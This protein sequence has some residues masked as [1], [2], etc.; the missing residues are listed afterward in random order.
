MAAKI[1]KG[2]RIIVTTGDFK[3]TVGTVL[4][5]DP[6][7]S[8]ATVEGVNARLVRPNRLQR[9]KNA[10]PYVK[11][12]PI[13][14]SNLSLFLEGEKKTLTRVFFSAKDGSKK[15]YSVKTREEI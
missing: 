14:I 13:H 12:F 5:I 3:G 11:L 15:R 9:Q 10:E 7:T 4:Q 8:R 1:K 2:D 6:K